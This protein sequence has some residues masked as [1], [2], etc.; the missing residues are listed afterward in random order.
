M[1]DEIVVEC[2]A[3]EAEAVATWLT[4]HM[5]AAGRELLPDV[6]V[7]AEASIMT[8]WSGTPVGDTR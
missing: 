1:H 4:G 2:D 7:V 6:P 3:G 5:E 8:D